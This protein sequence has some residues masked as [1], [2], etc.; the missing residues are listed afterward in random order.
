VFVYIDKVC[1]AMQR[2]SMPTLCVKA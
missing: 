2:I 1:V